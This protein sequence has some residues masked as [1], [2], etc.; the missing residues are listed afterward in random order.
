MDLWGVFFFFFFLGGG[1][2]LR[3]MPVCFFFLDQEA[4][5]QIPELSS[6]RIEKKK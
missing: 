5:D 2:R 3:G 6:T 1:G 4:A